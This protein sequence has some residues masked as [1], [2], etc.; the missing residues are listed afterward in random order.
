MSSNARNAKARADLIGH[1]IGEVDRES[2][3]DDRAL[4]RSAEGSVRLCA[5]HPHAS[6]DPTA[7]DTGTDGVDDAGAVA[8]RDDSGVRH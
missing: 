4:G 2:L 8:M 7:C 1:V 3:G 5:V 6:P